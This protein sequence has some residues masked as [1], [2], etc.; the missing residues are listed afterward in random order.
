MSVHCIYLNSLFIR[1]FAFITSLLR[2]YF[3][4]V[5]QINFLVGRP[6]LSTRLYS[7]TVRR[8]QLIPLI[9]TP[10]YVV[11]LLVAKGVLSSF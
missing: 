9:A 11:R 10:A 6:L 3:G 5:G 7:Y 2:V 4:R 1:N 8:H